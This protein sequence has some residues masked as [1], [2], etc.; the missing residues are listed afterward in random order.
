MLEVLLHA[1]IDEV[2]SD[3]VKFFTTDTMKD[4]RW[5]KK[6]SMWVKL[7]RVWLP[8]A[9]IVIATSLIISGIFN[10]IFGNIDEN[11]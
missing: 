3:K 6:A 10:V 5:W 7:A 11:I 4:E 8:L 1:I 2:R 9:Y